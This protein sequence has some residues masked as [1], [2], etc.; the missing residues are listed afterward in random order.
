MW[1]YANTKPFY[2]V[3]NLSVLGFWYPRG[4][5]PGINPLQIPRDTRTNI[6]RTSFRSTYTKIGTNISNIETIKYTLLS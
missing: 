2:I 1:L 4:W 3:R 6:S 5:N